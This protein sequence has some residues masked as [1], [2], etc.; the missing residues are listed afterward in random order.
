MSGRN[1]KTAIAAVKLGIF[2]LV[3]ILVTGLLAVIMG[4][5][6]F[7]SQSQYHALFS[8][9]SELKKGDDVRVAGVSVGEVKDV[10][11]EGRDHAIVTFKVQSGV[12]MTT[13]SGAQVRFLNLVGDRYLALTQGKPGA[14]RLRPGATIPM[15]QTTPA[16]DLT[17]LFNGFQPLFQALTPADVNK[18]SMNLVRVL[19]GEGGTIQGLLARTASLTN[20]LADRDQLVGEVISNLSG[21][22][23]TVDDRHQQLTR[24][25]VQLRDWLGHLST[26]RKAIGASLQNVS[27]LT[28]EVAGL[29]TGARPYAKQDIAQLRRVMSILNRPANQKLMSDTLKRLP[30]TLRRQARIGTFGSWYNY[31]LCDFTGKVILPKLGQL[32]GLG[33]AGAPLDQMMVKLQQQ[34]NENMSVYSTAKRC[35]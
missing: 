26:D 24:L 15:S 1:T 2:T 19:Q 11:L 4:H 9:A 34:I 16:L 30:T 35:D 8:S 3:S 23:K 17:A 29:V 7:G 31:Y 20:A 27:S 10:S 13:A 33:A 32:L 5:F 28:H 12:P 14:P 6:G 18:L 25:V 21:T 22:L